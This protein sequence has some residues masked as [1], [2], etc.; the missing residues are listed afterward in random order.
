M[1]IPSTDLNTVGEINSVRVRLCHKIH[2]SL[3]GELSLPL[4]S[5]EDVGATWEE[6]S[7]VFGNTLEDTG[8]SNPGAE[9]SVGFSC[10][11]LGDDLL[12]FCFLLFSRWKRNSLVEALIV[13]FFEDSGNTSTSQSCRYNMNTD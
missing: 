1:F 3:L 2:A 6:Q 9:C 12:F 4:V 11:A 13:L 7:A 8:V 5:F 10:W